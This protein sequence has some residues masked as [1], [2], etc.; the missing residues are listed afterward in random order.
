MVNALLLMLCLVAAITNLPALNKN[1]SALPLGSSL[2]NKALIHC[3][4]IAYYAAGPVEHH[5]DRLLVLE[6]AGHP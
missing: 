6:S 1:V 3:S 2:P 4:F 5:K